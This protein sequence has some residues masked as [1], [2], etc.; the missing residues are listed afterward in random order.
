MKKLNWADRILLVVFISIFLLLVVLINITNNRIEK[1]LE[2]AIVQSQEQEE[3][4]EIWTIEGS[5]ADVIGEVI[6]LYKQMYP[7]VTFKFKVFNRDIYNDMVFKASR[8]NSLPDMFFSWG[9]RPL[10]ELVELGVIADITKPVI[11]ELS[12]QLYEDT[13]DKYTFEDKIYGLPVFG[14]NNVLYCNMELFDFQETI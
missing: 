14:W 12:N 6:L 5:L 13:L 2:E 4:F 8:T 1:K 7:D 10:E 9:D 11:E 3:I